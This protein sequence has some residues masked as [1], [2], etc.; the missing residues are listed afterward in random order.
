M[1][2]GVPPAGL[3]RTYGTYADMFAQLLAGEGADLPHLP[4]AGRR[5][6]AA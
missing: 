5:T 4:Y 3:D 2:T 1:E 6:A